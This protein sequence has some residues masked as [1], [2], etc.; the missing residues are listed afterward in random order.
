MKLAGGIGGYHQEEKHVVF[1]VGV[2]LSTMLCVCQGVCCIHLF[3][4]SH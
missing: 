3:I 1:S 2:K 4:M